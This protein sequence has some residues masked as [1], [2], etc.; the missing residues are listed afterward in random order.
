MPGHRLPWSRAIATPYGVTLF[1]KLGLIVPLLLL[2][3]FNFLWVRPRLA[4]DGRALQSL[5]R[6]VVGQVVLVVLVLLS[7]GVL[8]SLEPGR[9]AVA[10][11]ATE[12]ETMLSFNDH[13]DDVHITLQVT[14]GAVGTNKTV[15]FLHD[16][17]GSPIP[18]S[19]VSLRFRYLDADLGEQLSIA[20]P[21]GEG[22]YVIENTFLN[23][24]GPW[25]A[26]LLVIR[27]DA[28]D[29]RANFRFDVTTTPISHSQVTALLSEMGNMLWGVELML[30]GFLFGGV[31]VPL[32]SK[33]THT[34]VFLL[35]I[36]IASLLTGII[37]I[38]VA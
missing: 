29:T 27:P 36:G 10:Q 19:Q 6:T 22:K 21:A 11:Y 31:A 18:T 3:A 1:V 24:A 13:V 28:F 15:L 8:T 23:A 2:G 35:G 12:Q 30:L 7:V 16:D 25:Q 14:P 34:G 4:R 33:K 9:Q 17:S 20:L 5:R 37:V 32:G 26:E 38:A